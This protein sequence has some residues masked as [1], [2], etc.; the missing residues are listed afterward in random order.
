DTMRRRT[1]LEMAAAAGA[2]TL[3]SGIESGCRPASASDAD[4]TSFPHGDLEE[5]T[6]L[7]LSTKMKRGDLRAVDLVDR[8]LA[9]IEAIDRR[10]PRLHSVLEIDPDARAVAA[11]LDEER[12][13][14]GVRGPLHGIPVLV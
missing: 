4:C 11:E 6:V 13:R 1:F 10:G 14:Q 2:T 3:L 12:R 8:Y 9:R 5:A 7:D